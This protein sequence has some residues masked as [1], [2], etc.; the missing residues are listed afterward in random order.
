ML[1]ILPACFSSL[2]VF[3]L[4]GPA[5][6]NYAFHLP[7]PL[8]LKKDGPCVYSNS[9][10]VIFLSVKNFCYLL[11]DK[12]FQFYFTMLKSCPIVKLLS[13]TKIFPVLR[14]QST[15]L[16]LLKSLSTLERQD[17]IFHT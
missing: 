13:L 11:G 7:F 17:R 6:Q 8:V 3:C 9:Q 12:A 16:A 4:L 1:S 2:L 14:S 15:I 10:K 5:E